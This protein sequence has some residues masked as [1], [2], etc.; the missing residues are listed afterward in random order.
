MVPPD[1]AGWSRRFDHEMAV[2]RASLGHVPEI[3]HI[4]STALAIESKDVV[5]VLVGVEPE[6]HDSAITRLRQAGYQLDGIRRTAEG[7]RH[8]WLARMVDQQRVTVVHVVDLAGAEWRRRTR[9]R[10]ALRADRALLEAYVALK[11]EI[12]RSTD[13]WSEYTAR[14]ADFV[15]RIVAS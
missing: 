1:D 3:E 6:Q 8:S 10:D 11:R 13:D 7:E 15:Q 2:L 5:D 14:K 12:A 4:G 9:F